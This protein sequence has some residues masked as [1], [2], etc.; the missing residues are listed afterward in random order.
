[1]TQV[2]CRMVAWELGWLGPD[3]GDCGQ[4]AGLEVDPPS[5][6]C[7]SASGGNRTKTSSGIE[8]WKVF[9]TSHCQA[10]T[11]SLLQVGN[12][13]KGCCRSHPQ[14]TTLGD[15]SF[16]KLKHIDCGDACTFLSLESHQLQRNEA[17][18][19]R[20]LRTWSADPMIY[21]STKADAA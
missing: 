17:M 3:A 4:L 16:T 21:I 20:K 5:G 7:G 2:P 15:R 6:I 18:R 1:M 19:F 8:Q 14:E 9:W 12:T 13:S 11:C 10:F